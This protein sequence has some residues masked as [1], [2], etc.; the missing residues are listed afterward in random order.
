MTA[1]PISILVVDDED[2]VREFI[3]DALTAFGFTA[4]VSA[5]AGHALELLAVHWIDLVLC[6]IQLPDRSGVDLARQI[7]RKNPDLPI[8]MITGSAD[9]ENAIQSLQLG[10]ADFLEKPFSVQRLL[11]CV[12]SVVD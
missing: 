9:A 4:H 5:T 3:R 6:D 10:A 7:R 8:V 12:R 11:S 1:E 2:T